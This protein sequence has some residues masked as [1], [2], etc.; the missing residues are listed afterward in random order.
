MSTQIGTAHFSGGGN[1]AT[2]W[3]H[4]VESMAAS[5]PGLVAA[6]VAVWLTNRLTI[7]R[8]ERNR[9]AERLEA[10][11][12]HEAERA[13]SIRRESTQRRLTAMEKLTAAVI[14]MTTDLDRYASSANN[15]GEKSDP[16]LSE[17]PNY[18]EAS[19]FV[20]MYFHDR[21]D[22]VWSHYETEFLRA[23]VAISIYIREMK[24][25]QATSLALIAARSPV[26]PIPPAVD[27]SSQAMIA[28]R[29]QVTVAQQ[30]VVN[31]IREIAP[32]LL[33]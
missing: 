33:N 31:R 6:I 32:E 9:V 18:Q 12:K 27:S 7:R 22:P 15:P 28:A 14:G 4:V 17:A 13:E 8:D 26:G 23:R 29:T 1:G 19:S 2:G 21:L 20:S 3:E 10:I 25:Y 16:S 30:L 11:R 5:A 24:T